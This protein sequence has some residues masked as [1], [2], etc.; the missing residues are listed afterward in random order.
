MFVTL[1]EK[2]SAFP[3][4]TS[5]MMEYLR[6]PAEDEALV[7]RLIPRAFAAFTKFTNGHVGAAARY[8]VW[9]D[10]AEIGDAAIRLPVHPILTRI[11]E[12]IAYDSD[13]E[14]LEVSALGLVGDR[15]VLLLE[16]VPSSARDFRSVQIV[17]SVGYSDD[18]IPDDILSGIEQFVVH[19][20]ERRGDQDVD[21]PD[22]VARLW[23]PYVLHQLG[24]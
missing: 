8:G 21:I 19:L 7:K 2:A 11:N 23:A 18:T 13:D 17:V 5:S 6:A 10:R 12:A 1:I 20:Y 16:D 9:L 3:I 24:G 14:E 22:A 15:S 4:S